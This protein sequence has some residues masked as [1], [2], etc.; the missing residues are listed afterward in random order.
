MN[1][2]DDINSS[3]NRNS[4][5]DNADDND[6]EEHELSSNDPQFSYSISYYS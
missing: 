4:N 6:D 5:R 1:N 2:A 3:N